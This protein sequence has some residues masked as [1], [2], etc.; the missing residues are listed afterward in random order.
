MCQFA[1]RLNLHL[2]QTRYADFAV[3]DSRSIASDSIALPNHIIYSHHPQEIVQFLGTM[4][5]AEQYQVHEQSMAALAAPSSLSFEEFI[6]TAQERDRL[7]SANWRSV[8]GQPETVRSGNI[9]CHP[10]LTEPAECSQRLRAAQPSTPPTW[11]HRRSRRQCSKA[12]QP[13]RRG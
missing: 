4:S 11:R 2:I 9:R 3:W 10:R 8:L 5:I 13:R 7:F 6:Q 12:R 1:G